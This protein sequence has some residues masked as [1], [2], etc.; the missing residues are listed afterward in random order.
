MKP[1]AHDGICGRR[2]RYLP[3]KRDWLA[4]RRWCAMENLH[5]LVLWLS[6]FLLAD[7]WVEVEEVS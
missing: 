5:E 4:P 3:P 6:G 1:Y 2:F 7:G